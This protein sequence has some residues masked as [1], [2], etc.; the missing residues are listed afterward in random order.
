[1]GR[2]CSLISVARADE[3]SS[4]WR[5]ARDLWRGCENVRVGSGGG[6]GR[7][8]P[9]GPVWPNRGA[10]PKAPT[11]RPGGGRGGGPPA[12][13]P[14]PGRPN[15]QPGPGRA[16]AGPWHAGR[17]RLG[18]HDHRRKGVLPMVLSPRGILA[19]GLSLAGVAYLISPSLGQAQQP[20]ADSGVRKAGNANTA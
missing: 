16:G 1:P 17:H 2:S 19:L 6:A 11:L 12:P 7:R 4:E 15:S 13:P 5:A 9:P 3:V 14:G 18:R 20:A 8:K 10:A